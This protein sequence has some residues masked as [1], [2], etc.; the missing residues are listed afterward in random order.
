M[1]RYSYCTTCVKLDATKVAIRLELQRKIKW[2]IHPE[3]VQ[4][5]E[6]GSFKKEE[7]TKSTNSFVIL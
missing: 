6:A 5:T 4:F 1:E 3:I 2:L 7:F